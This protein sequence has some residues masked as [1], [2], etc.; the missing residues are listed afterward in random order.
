MTLAGLRDALLGALQ[1]AAIAGLFVGGGL[2][3]AAAT[4]GLASVRPGAAQYP[5]PAMAPRLWLVDGFNVIQVGLLAGRDRTGWWRDE[6]RRELLE[7]AALLAGPDDQV[8][9]VFDGARPAGEPP[10]GAHLRAVFAETADAWLLEQVAAGAGAR[11]HVVTAD[12][13]L[14]ER[15]RRRGAQVVTP[16][17]F[18]SRCAAAGASPGPD[19]SGIGRS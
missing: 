3:V 14:G 13:S 5:G 2:G 6:R 18:L 12:R 4:R 10:P 9:V 16:R 1:T 15:A 7:R 8:A 11:V 17:E 19:P